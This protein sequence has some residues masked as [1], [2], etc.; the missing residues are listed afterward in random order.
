MF[1]VQRDAQG[2]LLRVETQAFDGM[3]GE[4]AAD[5]QEAQDWFAN[6]QLESSLQQL[7]QSDLT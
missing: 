5:S 7:Q 3:S 4:I 1:Y 6:R 2:L